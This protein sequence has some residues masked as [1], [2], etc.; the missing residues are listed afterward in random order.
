MV[1]YSYSTIYNIYF[2]PLSNYPG[3]KFAAASSFWYARGLSRGTLAF[4]FLKLHDK[5]GPVVRVAPD[6][7]SYIDP[8]A[9]KEIYGHKVRGQPELEKDKKYHSGLAN[10]EPVI[11]N[12]DQHHHREIRRLMSHGFSDSALRGQEPLLQE[13]LHILRRKLAE[14]GQDGQV[15]LD[16]VSWYNVSKVYLTWAAACGLETWLRWMETSSLRS[17]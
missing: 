9:F 6:E 11:I 17:T 4:D 3:P 7:L 5:Y 2:H 14:N 15:P 12:A 10:Q 1:Y 16:M 8:G 13:Y